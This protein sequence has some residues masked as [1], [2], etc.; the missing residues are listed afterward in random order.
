[1][2]SIY[3]LFTLMVPLT[4]SSKLPNECVVWGK[5]CPPTPKNVSNLY[6][7]LIEEENDRFA[8]T[9]QNSPRR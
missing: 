7:L 2:G 5:C 3:L 4:T 8:N 9:L 1:M 6:T